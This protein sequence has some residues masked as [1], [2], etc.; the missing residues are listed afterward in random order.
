MSPSQS[1]RLSLPLSEEMHAALFA[2]ARRSGVPATR[3][4]R[5]ALEQWLQDR[6]RERRRM[7]IQR[8]AEQHGGGEYDFDPLIESAAA[9]ELVDFDE[10]DRETR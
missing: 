4:V 2:E 8:F 3:L 10:A 5:T 9:D 6:E 1:K 7:E